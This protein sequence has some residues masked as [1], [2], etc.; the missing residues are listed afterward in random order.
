[1][2]LLSQKRLLES[3]N[4]LRYPLKVLKRRTTMDKKI[5]LLGIDLSK[6]T[7]QCH[8]INAD[9][10]CVY[11]KSL[12]KTK[13]LEFVSNL[14]K[15]TIVTEACGGA[16][17]FART[18]Q[19]LGH[20]AKLIAPQFVKPFVK[21]NSNDATD[22]EAITEAALRP[23]MRFVPI[24]QEWQ[25]DLQCMHRVRQRLIRNKTAL[26]N[27]IRGLLLEYGIVIP[28]GD[29]ALMQKLSEVL[30]N[31]NQV[32]SER[33][34][35]VMQD[36]YSELIALKGKIRE[37]D[38]L[39]ETTAKKDE[40]YKRLSSVRGIGII[41]ITALIIALAD[42]FVF[43]NG[44]H[45]AAWL[46]LVPKHSGTGG[47]NRNMGISKRGE[48]YIR[49][50]MIHGARSVVHVVNRKA[51]KDENSLDPLEKWLFRLSKT[52]GTNRAAVALANKNARIVWALMAHKTEFDANIA[53]YNVLETAA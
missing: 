28:L 11:R 39:L 34:R 27:E 45:F 26:T 42:P 13:L 22:A 53:S 41:C 44:R 49:S 16:H 8:G 18:F 30:A 17:Y 36:L 5:V 25:Q 51:V 19:S 32:L 4:E 6:S 43:K 12:T 1:V 31:D 46:G 48:R 29:T 21:T 52:K 40:A 23:N 37:Y 20:E 14:S 15:C 47:V 9:G 7:F 35:F 3:Q 10:Q 24:K 33:S 2:V 38:K 50:L